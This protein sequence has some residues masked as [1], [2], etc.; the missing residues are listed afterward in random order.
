MQGFFAL[1][2]LTELI[3]FC[4]SDFKDLNRE[5]TF[6]RN[7]RYLQFPKGSVAVVTNVIKAQTYNWTNMRQSFKLA[8]FQNVKSFHY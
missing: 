2:L 7:R 6:S 5:V 4:G 1:L 3:S 8:T